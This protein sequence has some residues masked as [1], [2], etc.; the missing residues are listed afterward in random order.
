MNP[1]F[2]KIKQFCDENSG[3]FI[4]GRRFILYDFA[5]ALVKWCNNINNEMKT[6]EETKNRII[7][8]FGEFIGRTS[9]EEGASAS[10]IVGIVLECIETSI[11]SKLVN[12]PTQNESPQKRLLDAVW[13]MVERHR[14]GTMEMSQEFID[15]NPDVVAYCKEK[16]DVTIIPEKK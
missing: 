6:K 8:K 1:N 13:S 7:F 16:Y 3:R 10:W 9:K 2:D 5:E 15:S 14:S 4:R 12:K 11:L